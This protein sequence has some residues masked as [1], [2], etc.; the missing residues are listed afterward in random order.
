ML[1]IWTVEDNK[2]YRESLLSLIE[3]SKLLICTG[4]FASGE[5]ALEA[6]KNQQSPDVILMDINMGAMDGISC[7]GHLKKKWPL[8][9]IVM[10]TINDDD[11]SIFR[12]LEEGASGYLLKDASDVD[13]LAA[14]DLAVGGGM[15]MPPRV[16][17]R[18]LSSFRKAE[19]RSE[20]QKLTNAE[21]KV[22]EEMA[23]G[24]SQ[25]EIG[26]TLFISTH[27]VNSH[28]KNIYQKLHAGSNVEAVVKAIQEGLIHPKRL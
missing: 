21:K 3:D 4:A 15:P 2:R 1:R 6:Q 16:A 11:Q 12:A 18:V 26:E 28:V 27:T 17:Q 24:R 13:L 19:N 5:E 25:K 8:V 20:G 23:K 22:L 7:V 9:T 14:I 10:L